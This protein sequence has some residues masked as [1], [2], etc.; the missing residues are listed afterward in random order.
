MSPA[1]EGDR[2]RAAARAYL[3]YALVYWVGGVY[4]VWHG[5]GVPGGATGGRWAAYLAFWIAVG[6]VPTFVI[7]YLL[8]RPRAWFERWILTR[9]DFARL[10]AL[11]MAWRAWVVLRVALRPESATVPAPWGG[12]IAFRVGA[13]VFF[14]VTVGALVMVVRAAWTPAG[15]RA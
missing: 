13:I 10:L 6:A 1:G 7:P 4:L 8:R 15:E 9:R 5:V 11:V 2:F 3:A 12:D 14:V